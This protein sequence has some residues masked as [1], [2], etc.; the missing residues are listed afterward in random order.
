MRNI[1][2]KNP[3]M[4]PLTPLLP[5][6]TDDAGENEAILPPAKPEPE[7]LVEPLVPEFFAA[8]EA[9]IGDQIRRREW[10]EAT[11]AKRGRWREVIFDSD[12]VCAGCWRDVS[13]CACRPLW[14]MELLGRRE[15]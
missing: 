6:M 7:R 13:T 11:A 12:R 5:L 9:W 2:R 8:F 15:L 10:A 14:Q 1:Y 3:N 4:P